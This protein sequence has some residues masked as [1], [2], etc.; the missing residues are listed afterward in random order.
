MS[1]PTN[2]YATFLTFYHF[3]H[4]DEESVR[5]QPSSPI[6]SRNFIESVVPS[7]KIIPFPDESL[8]AIPTFIPQPRINPFCPIFIHSK[9]S[10]GIVENRI[11]QK[12]KSRSGN[13][14]T[15]RTQVQFQIENPARMRKP[16]VKSPPGKILWWRNHNF[17]STFR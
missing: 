12:G 1:I 17:T 10:H 5:I 15:A 14:S 11:I 16:R 13:V 8:V 7:S 3:H 4:D 9:K 6:C 2:I